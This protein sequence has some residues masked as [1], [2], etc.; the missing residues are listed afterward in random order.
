MASS[1]D[2]Q[3]NVHGCVLYAKVNLITKPINSS[4]WQKTD[5]LSP[6]LSLYDGSAANLTEKTELLIEN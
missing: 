4:N 1:Q 5:S 3:E 6:H 2:P